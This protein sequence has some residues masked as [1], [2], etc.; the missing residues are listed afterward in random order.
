[1]LRWNDVEEQE[2]YDLNI[3]MYREPY[4]SDNTI[5]S[6]YVDLELDHYAYKYFGS[7]LFAYRILDINFIQYMEER[8]DLYR[9]GTVLIPLDSND[10]DTVL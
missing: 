4:N 6:K 3:K 10:S 1:M 7:E 8:G 9:L 2:I 5:K